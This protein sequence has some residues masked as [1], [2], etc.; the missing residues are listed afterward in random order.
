VIV[1]QVARS[2]QANEALLQFGSRN[3]QADL[4]HLI[5]MPFVAASTTLGALVSLLAIRLVNGRDWTRKIALRR[6]SLVHLAIVLLAFPALPI[7]ASGVYQVAKNLLPS[8]PELLRKL[9]ARPAVVLGAVPA[10]QRDESPDYG[11]EQVVQEARSWPPFLAVLLIGL[12]PGISEEL[13]CRGFL[14]RGLVGKHGF[15]GGILLTSLF[16]GVIHMDLPQGIMAACMGVVLHYAYVM[17]RSLFVPMLLHFLN[18]SLAVIGDRISPELGKVDTDP[19]AI[20]GLLYVWSILV[21]AAAGYALYRG[22]ARLALAPGEPGP[23]W[24]PDFPS[25]EYPPRGSGTVV[26]RPWPGWLA[27]LLVALSVAGLIGTFIVMANRAA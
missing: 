20:P 15:V 21:L 27:C 10:D 6:P 11:M 24:R 14:G 5:L 8:T 9:T 4:M 16:F 2:P 17:T 1:V 23:A 13:W 19:N 26:I 22:R 12:G 25:V 3:G 7:A 18:N